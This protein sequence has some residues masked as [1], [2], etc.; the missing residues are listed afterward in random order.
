MG[1]VYRAVQ[2]ELNEPVA[3]K[4][5]HGAFVSD[6]ELRVRFRREAVALARL[7]HPS[8]VSLLDFGESDAKDP[9]MVMELVD[10]EPFGRV[11]T[12]AR[13]TLS[14]RRIGVIFDFLLEALD[15]AHSIGIVHRD[16]KPSNIMVL[17]HDRIKV[18]DFGLVHLPGP[19]T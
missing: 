4:F 9:F 8:I 7:R 5:L 12:T 16:I 14:L 15:A 3:V 13:G 17:D 2:T 6:P 19:H 10:G 18:L 1:A 11:L